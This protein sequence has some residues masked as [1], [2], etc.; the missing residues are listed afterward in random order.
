M[1][2]RAR[3]NRGNRLPTAG[4]TWRR[5]VRNGAA[6]YGNPQLCPRSGGNDGHWIKKGKYLL[7]MV[8]GARLD[9]QC[10]LTCAG[11]VRLL[12]R[13]HWFVETVRQMC[14][15]RYALASEFLASGD[16]VVI[17]GR[18][19]EYLQG[20]VLALRRAH[21]KSQV[22]GRRCDV[23]Q[24]Q[25][26]AEFA[27]FAA[28]QLGGLDLWLNNAGQVTSKRLLADVPASEIAAV[29]GVNVV[30]SLLGC[31]EATGSQFIH[32]KGQAPGAAHCNN[33]LT[34]TSTGPRG[35]SAVGGEGRAGFSSW[36]AAL[37]KTAVTHKATKTALTQL[38][39]SLCQ[40]L[41]DSGMS[42][43]GVHNLS[44]GLVLTDLL[45]KDSSPVARRFFNALAEEAPTVAAALV[46][47][48]RSVQGTGSSIDYLNP[49]TAFLKV[50]AGVPQILGG[51]RFFDREGN[52]VPQKGE[53]YQANGVR[54]PF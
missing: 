21:P 14:M 39:A 53:Q 20:A 43:I 3:G 27:E 38:T 44:P 50:A 28:A 2:P 6:E 17:C 42:S 25:D 49:A 7:R 37:S 31:R 52:R 41:Q 15:P 46:P 24:A 36:G 35:F 10:K 18:D 1:C 12:Y 19:A 13:P 22:H 47:R 54:I 5:F 11:I 48:I 32:R 4:P 30:G 23:S 45:L 26:I 16:A 51:G 29:A 8:G 33:I 34:S 9:P 40:E